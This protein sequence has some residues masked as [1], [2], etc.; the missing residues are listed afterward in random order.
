MLALAILTI[1]AAT[2]QQPDAGRPSVPGEIGA[3]V[4]WSAI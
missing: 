3:D 1:L 4:A 2:A